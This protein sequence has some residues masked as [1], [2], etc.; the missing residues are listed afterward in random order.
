MTESEILSYFS[1]FLVE[2]LATSADIL[3]GFCQL[4]SQ[5]A[6]RFG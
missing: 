3:D 2:Y 6:M 5:F 1:I 4:R